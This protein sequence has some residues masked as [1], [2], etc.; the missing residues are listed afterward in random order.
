MRGGSSG[1]RCFTRGYQVG[2]LRVD[3]LVNEVVLVELK[4]V[5]GLDD[6]RLVQQRN[7]CTCLGW[8]WDR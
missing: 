4:A 6:L 1:G 8:R 5:S 3:F 2:S 7:F